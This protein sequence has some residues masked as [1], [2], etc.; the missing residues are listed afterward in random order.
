MSML[1]A[2]AVALVLLVDVSGSV[3][4]E[5]YELQ[6][7]GIIEAF[8]SEEI[9]KIIENSEGVAVS[10]VEWGMASTTMIPWQILKDYNS[11]ANFIGVYASTEKSLDV[12]FRMDTNI[13]G[14]LDH[15]IKEFEKVPCDPIQ[16]IIDVSGD[17]PN[18]NH[19]PT[20][21]S[22]QRAEELLITINGLPI[23]SNQFPKL[24]EYYRENVTTMN[25]FVIPAEGFEDF[26]RAIRMK[27][28]REIAEGIKN[29]KI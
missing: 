22:I 21:F 13:T 20:R 9:V 12:I 28:I 8:K 25:G 27:L 23:L 11:I 16:K 3:D 24:D 26:G 1:A 5:E 14:A 10:V 2:C 17:G 19:V 15:A 7:T 29:G 18:G 6:K 4:S